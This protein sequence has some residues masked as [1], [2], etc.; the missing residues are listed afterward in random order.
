MDFLD[1]GLLDILHANLEPMQ[2][3][4]KTSD[5]TRNQQHLAVLRELQRLFEINSPLLRELASHR[6]AI[7]TQFQTI[8]SKLL[9]NSANERELGKTKMK[10]IETSSKVPTLLVTKSFPP[11]AQ[12]D[13]SESEL[14]A[15][16]EDSIT[17]VWANTA[18]SQVSLKEL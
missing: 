17:G 6:Q 3:T 11:T 12:N 9:E 2:H 1:P 7:E 18:H 8:L 4:I 5:R 10:D 16:P 13:K 15:L 14:T